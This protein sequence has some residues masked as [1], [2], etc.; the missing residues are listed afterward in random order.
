MGIVE[1]TSCSLWDSQG[2]WI[3]LQASRGGRGSPKL[4]M[5]RMMHHGIAIDGTSQWS[6]SPCFAFLGAGSPTARNRIGSWTPE[7]RSDTSES[8]DDLGHSRRVNRS[9][10][11]QR[12]EAWSMD[13]KGKTASK[14]VEDPLLNRLACPRQASSFWNWTIMFGPVP[15]LHR[16]AYFHSTSARSDGIGRPDNVCI[17]PGQ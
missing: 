2:R 8:A 10:W 1:W 5:T 9:I 6:G 3:L 7:S 12:R 17:P 4:R 15:G 16:A 11:Y 14:T 13:R